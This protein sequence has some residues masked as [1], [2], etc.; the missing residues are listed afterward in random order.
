MHL[1]NI[2]FPK[3]VQVMKTYITTIYSYKSPNCSVRKHELK[4]RNS[5]VRT[6][7]VHYMPQS[8]HSKIAIKENIV[9]ERENLG[10]G[11]ST[12]TFYNNPFSTL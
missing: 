12:T 10:N 1:K 7:H 11:Y 5:C 4:S 9:N 6:Y 3:D 8:Q 2:Q